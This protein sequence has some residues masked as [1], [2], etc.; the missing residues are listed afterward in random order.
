MCW[1][2]HDLEP[3]AFKILTRRIMLIWLLFGSVSPDLFTKFF[4]ESGWL[5]TY[6]HRHIGIG[7]THTLF[8][9][10]VMACL[11][12]VILERRIGGSYA[13][14]AALS[15][16]I[17][18]WSHV[19]LDTLDSVG[20]MALFPLSTKLF[21][22]GLWSYAAQLGHWGDLYVFYHS[23]ALLIETT[24]FVLVWYEAWKLL[25]ING[26]EKLLEEEK[27]GE[28][29]G[30]RNRGLLY[31]LYFYYLVAS[32]RLPIWVYKVWFSYEPTTEAILL[33]HRNILYSSIFGN[34]LVAIMALAAM[35][36][37]IV[38]TLYN[39][40]REVNQ[41][42]ALLLVLETMTLAL[43]GLYVKNE[44][45]MSALSTITAALSTYALYKAISSKSVRIVVAFWQRKNSRSKRF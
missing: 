37:T 40:W 10:L 11:L 5:P 16:L 29:L 27:L 1:F 42:T 9:G 2:S 35:I 23:P 7:I 12:Y 6:Q 17:G 38:H 33:V 14:R 34:R 30:I 31:T 24:A 41:V 8:F 13:S 22:V 39:L 19:L 15:F 25:T 4:I 20:L 43:I 44:P 28:I 3:Y 45:L 18:Q 21:S 26:F 36:F 32:L